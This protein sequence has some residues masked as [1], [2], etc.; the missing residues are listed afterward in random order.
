MGRLQLEALEDRTLLSG[1]PAGNTQLLQAYGNLPLSFE[2][3]Q[4]QTAPQ[5]NFLTRGHGYALFLTPAEAVLALSQGGEENVVRMEL[6]GGNPAAQAEGLDQQAG[7]SNYYVGSDPGQWITNVPHYSRVEYPGVYPGIDLHYYGNSQTQLEYDF[8]VAP[9]ASPAAIKLAFRGAQAVSLDGQ[10]NLVLHTA[11]GDVVEQAP[12][13]YQVMAGVRQPV[14]AHYLLEANGRLG[15]ALGAYDPSHSLIIDPILSYS[16]YLGGSGGDSSD[17]IAVDSA[18]NA[19]ITGSTGSTDFPTTTGVTQATYSGGGDAFVT[20][21]NASGTALVYSTYLGGSGGDIAYGIAVDASGDAYVTGYTQSLN[22]PTVNGSSKPNNGNYSVFVSKLNASGTA[23]VYSTCLGGNANS[24]AQAIAVDS[25]GSAYITGWSYGGFPTTPGALQPTSGGPADAFIAKLNASGTGLVYSTYLGGSGN[26]YGFGIAL[27]ASGNAFVTGSTSGNF[28]T[29]AGAFQTTFGGGSF[30]GDAFVSKLN[31]TGTTLVYSTYLGGSSDERAFA[32]AVDSSGDAYVTGNTSSTNFPTT[33]GAYET[34]SNGNFITKLNASGS[35]LLYSTYFPAGTAGIAVDSAGNAYVTGVAG[36]GFPTTAGAF[37]TSLAGSQNA[38]VTELNASGSTLVYSTYL[39]GSSSDSGAAIAV[40]SAGGIYVAGS[41][42]S[43]NF[44]TSAG[45]F[46]TT[47]GGAGNAFVT[48]FAPAAPPSLLVSGF[49]SPT[50]AGV[51]GTFTVTVKNHDGS[52]DTGYTGTVHFTSSDLQAGLPAN[53]TFTSGDAGVHTFSAAL[54]TA[55]TQSITVTDTGTASLTGSQTGIVVTAAATSKLV[56]AGFPSPVVAGTAGNV[57]VT[58]E[59][60]YG[61][62]TPSYSGTVHFT[63][64]DSRKSLPANYTFTASDNGVHTFT[65]TLRTAGTQTIG[66]ADTT[67]STIQGAQTGIVVV[68]N[69][70]THFNVA[71]FPSPETAGVTGAFRVIAR[72]AY[73]NTVTNYTGTVH[74]TTSD[75]SKGARL[76]ANYTFTSTDKGI[77]TFHATL[78]TAGTQS[79]T[80]T[81]TATNSITGSQTGIIIAPAAVNHFRVYGFP[82]PTTAGVAHSFIVQA[83]DLYGNIVTGYTGTVSFSSSDSQATLPGPYSFTAGDAGRHTFSGTLLTVG[84]QSI[85]VKDTVS[86]SITGAQT[87]IVV[88]AAGTAPVSGRASEPGSTLVRPRPNEG[89]PGTESFAI[90]PGIPVLPAS[91]AEGFADFVALW[92]AW[93]DPGLGLPRPSE[94]GALGDLLAPGTQEMPGLRRLATE[95]LF[96]FDGVGEGVAPNQTPGKRFRTTAW[97]DESD[98]AG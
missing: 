33:A 7:I 21:L 19:Y 14:A 78:F 42:T 17:G 3:N 94:L 6:V 69:V 32:I 87:G 36:S 26:D 12:V 56:V 75:P 8:D 45:A 44:P 18:G 52:T 1:A 28:P 82:N 73:N 23:L 67:T 93:D 86:S 11:G 4:G 70:V 77:H 89:L 22:F 71:L 49:P 81:D 5:V 57:T 80:A 98:S 40:D 76:P 91:A 31:A 15:F 43:S 53:Y 74:F 65:A 58:A 59:D 2:A 97:L 83:K 41:T 55:G 64:G 62:T 84:T 25:S 27:D 47:Y 29:T 51:A 16:T 90:A 48:K 68:H 88:N 30:P 92:A 9:D 37:Q 34:N 72:D 20:K 10:G 79:L 35:A 13:A 24:A 39:G 50:T 61:N 60:A 63:S 85:T 38:F 95:Q 96:D 46:Q 66:V 54:K